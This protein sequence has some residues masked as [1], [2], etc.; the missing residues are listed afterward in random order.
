[1]YEIFSN[2]PIASSGLSGE[3]AADNGVDAQSTDDCSNSSRKPTIV[4]TS[5]FKKGDIAGRQAHLAR[6]CPEIFSS[7]KKAAPL[8]TLRAYA[9][10]VRCDANV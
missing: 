3:D 2:G 10:P 1:M 9:R 6:A 4:F 5:I 8:A 7:P